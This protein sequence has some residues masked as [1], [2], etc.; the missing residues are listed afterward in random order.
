MHYLDG[1]FFFGMHLFWWLFWIVV[2]VAFFT[3]ATPVPR[4]KAR[5]TPL[6]RLQHRYANG[7]ISTQEYEERK[8]RL[9]QDAP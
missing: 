8:K 1:S 7:D 5:Q 6:E 2:I 3:L 4:R 9:E